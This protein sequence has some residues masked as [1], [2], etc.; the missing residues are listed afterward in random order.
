M[1]IR[2]LWPL[3][4]VYSVPV[5][6]TQFIFLLQIIHL[7][8]VQDDSFCLVFLKIA[9]CPFNLLSA[10]AA[11]IFHLGKICVI[12]YLIF[13]W[14]VDSGGFSLKQVLKVIIFLGVT[15]L[16]FT[17]TAFSSIHIFQLLKITSL[18][19]KYSSAICLVYF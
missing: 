2:I 10:A 5:H 3:L 11:Y 7:P 4:R 18:S 8:I 13:L 12:L 14:F 9:I 1:M 6:L 16:S 19:A 17:T 15:P